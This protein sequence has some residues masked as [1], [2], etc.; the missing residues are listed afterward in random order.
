MD[1]LAFRWGYYDEPV[2]RDALSRLVREVFGLDFGPW[3]ALGCAGTYTP[4]SWWEGDRVVANVSASPMSLRVLGRPVEAI[5]V[6]TVAVAPSHRSRGLVRGLLERA[7][8]HWAPTHDRWYLFAAP[9]AAALYER[10][11]YRP[12]AETSWELPLAERPEARPAPRA[13]ARLLDLARATDRD[14]VVRLGGERAPVSARVGVVDHAW[15]LSFYAAVAYPQGLLYVEPLDA[16]ALLRADG[17]RL[18]LADVVGPRT[19]TLAELLPY[20]PLGAAEAVSFG[21]VPDLLELPGAPTTAVLH[22]GLHVRGPWVE[23]EGRPL[24]FPETAQA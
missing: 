12:L 18:H 8:A 21:F 22:D 6:G 23:L 9:D 7:H 10:F 3:S 19:V 13:G 15:L 11:G 4:F 1:S 2:G 14:L 20:L 24:R 5:Q 17:A 16:L